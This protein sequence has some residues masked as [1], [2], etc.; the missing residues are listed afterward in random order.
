MDGDEVIP[1]CKEKMEKA[2]EFLKSEYRTIRSGRASAGLV[3]NIKVDYYGSPTPLNQLAGIAIPEGRLIV[4]K[5]FDK[6]VIGNIEK[7]LLKSELGITPSNDGK[8]IR[9]QVPALSEENRRHLVAQ[10]KDMAE[11][12]HVSIRN[13]RR[14]GIRGIDA[15]EKE[16][17]MSEDDARRYKDEIQDLTKKCEAK[18]A[19]VLK[20]KTTELMEE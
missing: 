5:P 14:E 6:S 15:L 19:E 8:V 3:E 1:G 2:V 11:Q 4:I 7:A 9:L 17:K 10:V 20:A 12:Q 18:V 16:K 13:I